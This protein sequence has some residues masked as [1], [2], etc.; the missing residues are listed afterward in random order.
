MREVGFFA[1]FVGIESPDERTLIAMQKKQNTRRSI[2]ESV[3]KIYQHGIF[4]NAGFILGFDT[5]KGSVARGSSSASRTRRSRPCMV[6]LLSALP[7]T[8]LTRRLA[9]EGR[10]HEDSDL[11]PEA[12]AT[13]APRAST[14]TP[15]GPG[16]RSCAT[17][18]RSSRRPTR[19]RTISPGWPGWG[20]G[21]TAGVGAT[22]P[23][24]SG[25]PRN[26]V[27]S[28]VWPRR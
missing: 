18:S 13:S 28:F 27:A 12:S 16:S 8:Q 26:S 15:C 20:G 2:A 17:I 4:V 21:S 23:G 11:Q 24:S 14:S 22:G 10:L 3:E 5:E 7:N 1:I 25:G 19:P 9:T 6:G